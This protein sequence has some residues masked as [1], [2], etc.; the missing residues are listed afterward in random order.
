MVLSVFQAYFKT[1]FNNKSIV[2]GGAFQ[3]LTVDYINIETSS[4]RYFKPRTIINSVDH[5]ASKE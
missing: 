3:I 1:A 5:Q 4:M 2:E